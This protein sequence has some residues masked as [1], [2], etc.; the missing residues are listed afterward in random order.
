MA[1]YV[2]SG[3]NAR[4]FWSPAAID[5]DTNL[6][7][8]INDAL[9]HSGILAEKTDTGIPDTY[10][11]GWM[12][13]PYIQDIRFTTE[14]GLD[15][16]VSVG[17]ENIAAIE[18][19][20]I[21][22]Q[23]VTIEVIAQP[24]NIFKNLVRLAYRD[25]TQG[26]Y[27]LPFVF[28]RFFLVDAAEATSTGIAQ[29]H[30]RIDIWAAILRRFEFNQPTDGFAT[31]RFTFASN[32]IDIHKFTGD[33]TSGGAP[34]G[35]PYWQSYD[36][37]VG[38]LNAFEAVM[39]F[40]D[41]TTNNPH[42]QFQNYS[43]EIASFNFDV[44]TNITAFHTF[45]NAALTSDSRRAAL[46]LW[47]AFMDAVQVVEGGFTAY[48]PPD[49]GGSLNVHYL[50]RAKLVVEYYQYAGTGAITTLPGSPVLTFTF[51]YIKFLSAGTGF[52]PDRQVTFDVRFRAF[53]PAGM[54][55]SIT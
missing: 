48:L 5:S 34:S 21:G 9:S 23:D 24:N 20:G 33:W 2:L 50:D 25:P 30:Y 1:V 40:L 7:V 11:Q 12:G 3:R 29:V 44:T 35:Y 17:V 41:P 4:A 14:G 46:R 45:L 26:V 55:W 18:E 37:N 43:L 28:L 27:H 49:V 47:R 10:V 52:A 6:P 8:F 16:I 54:A 51:P 42:P 53:N 22:F 31:A 15:N 39:K 32:F 13:F 36:L 19:V 38:V